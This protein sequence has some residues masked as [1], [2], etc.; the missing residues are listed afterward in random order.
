VAPKTI[1]ML[2][3]LYGS[4]MESFDASETGVDL[5]LSKTDSLPLVVERAR[6]LV[7]NSAP[8]FAERK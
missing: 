4:E 8:K 1:I 3:T 7:R 5:V 6:K 2:F